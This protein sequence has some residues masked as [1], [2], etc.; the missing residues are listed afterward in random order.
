MTHCADSARRPDELRFD[1]VS[2]EA[3]GVVL[4]QS[5][6][7]ASRPAVAIAGNRAWI[8]SATEIYCVCHA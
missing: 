4:N 6:G 8:K 2:N 3:S 7:F 5:L 1:S